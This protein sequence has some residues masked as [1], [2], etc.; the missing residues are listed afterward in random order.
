M[1]H[2]DAVGDG[3][4][5]EFARRAAA[6]GDTVLHGLSLAHQRDIA[7]RRF[8][9]AGG[10]ADEGLVNLL[11][12]QSHRVIKRTVRSAVGA[13]SGVAAWQPQFQIR[14]CIHQIM[15]A[16]TGPSPLPTGPTTRTGIT[17][18]LG[19]AFRTPALFTF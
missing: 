8:V 15:R 11:S 6:G 2:G 17:R 18:R 1:A 14:L 5:A 9:P 13:F 10:D 7:G 19:S 16:Q 3:D 4:S 12:R